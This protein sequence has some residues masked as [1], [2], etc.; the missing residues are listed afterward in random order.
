VC[1]GVDDG[2]RSAWDAFDLRTPS[3]L[4]IEVKSCAYLQAWAHE[5]PS[6]IRFSIAPTRGWNGDTGTY[7]ETVERQSDVYVF[8]LLK[9]QDKPTLNPV[10]LD[11][12]EFYVVPTA[13]INA[14][15]G[16]AKAISLKVLLPLAGEP[17]PFS[18]LPS[19]VERIAAGV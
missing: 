9:H 3:G 6:T 11:Q 8:A 16:T 17:V 4:K 15:C 18:G 13:A 12:W 7:R 14:N 1:A 19:A 2:V 5:K 10:D